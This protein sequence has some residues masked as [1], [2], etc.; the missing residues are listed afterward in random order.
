[1]TDI[2]NIQVVDNVSVLR[3]IEDASI[4]AVMTL[5][6]YFP[7]DGGGGIY[8]YQDGD[9]WTEDSGGNV[10]ISTNKVRHWRLAEGSAQSVRQFGALGDNQHDDTDAIRRALEQGVLMVPEGNYLITD[11]TLL[12]HLCSFRGA[13]A[14]VYNGQSFLVGPIHSTITIHVPN[15]FATL[16]EAIACVELFEIHDG[17]CNIQV[18]DGTYEVAQ[19]SP[20]IN[21]GPRV[22]ILGNTSTPSNCVLKIACTSNQSC[23]NLEKG[24]SL[25][26]INGFTIQGYNGHADN[27][28]WNSECYG[29]G[30]HVTDGSSVNI[31]GAMI[32]NDMYYGIQAK[33]GASVNC[34]EGIIINRAGDCGVHAYAASIKCN[35]IKVTDCRDG[36]SLG[37]GVTAEAGGFV[38]ATNSEATG[39]YKAGFYSNGGHMWASRC[40]SHN[41]ITHGFY[42]LNGGMMEANNSEAYDN[43]DCGFVATDG[44]YLLAFDSKAER[45][46]YGFGAWHASAMDINGATANNNRIHGFIVANHAVMFHPSTSTNN[47][48]DGW[49]IRGNSMYAADSLTGSGNGGN[50]VYMTGRGMLSTLTNF[51]ASEVNTEVVV[52]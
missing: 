51:T 31:G 41:N 25:G 26:K 40:K 6:Y 4:K 20:Q 37:F 14:L 10:I 46:N 33:F 30:I 21:I 23:F 22:A 2:S 49:H 42:A 16:A 32:I 12:K 52:N 11:N 5:G 27:G 36:T 9:N 1:M 28:T 44:S 8:S 17:F 7:G 50:K 29:C 18:A 15:T 3:T 47:A 39:N 45:N 48:T 43:P 24:H 19:M 34:D 38:D 13:G 35:G